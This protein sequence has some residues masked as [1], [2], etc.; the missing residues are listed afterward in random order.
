MF[1]GVS[2]F[3]TNSVLKENGDYELKKPRRA[4]RDSATFATRRYSTVPAHAGRRG[5]RRARALARACVC[6][7][8]R[9]RAR[10]RVAHPAAHPARVRPPCCPLRGER[11]QLPAREMAGSE[12]LRAAI[13]GNYGHEEKYDRDSNSVITA[14]IAWHGQSH[15]GQGTYSLTGTYFLHSP[16]PCEHAHLPSLSGAAAGGGTTRPRAPPSC[17]AARRW[18]APAC[19][20]I[21]DVASVA[22]G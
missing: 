1:S 11:D 15:C 5:R 8:V 6:A 18:R 2:S 22:I 3:R 4:H 19:F 13:T 20:A 10:A 7:R 14:C 12:G 17:R 16:V 9:A 21:L